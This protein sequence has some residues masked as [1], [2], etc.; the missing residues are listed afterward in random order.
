MLLQKAFFPFK[1]LYQLS[2]LK[3]LSLFALGFHRWK[4]GPDSPTGPTLGHC[5]VTIDDCHTAWM[6][7]DDEVFE[8]VDGEP[9]KSDQVI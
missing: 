3:Y 1:Y 9:S 6:G 4:G 2:D 5:V 8:P 7:G